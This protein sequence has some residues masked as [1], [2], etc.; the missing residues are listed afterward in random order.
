[1]YE[2]ECQ[3]ISLR[4][5]GC[6]HGRGRGFYIVRSRY[7]GKTSYE[8]THNRKQCIKIKHIEFQKST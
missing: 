7:W 6:V 2:Y 4:V 1:M 5:T 3:S 8:F